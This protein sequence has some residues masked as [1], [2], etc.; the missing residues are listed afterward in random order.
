MVDGKFRLGVRVDP[1][2]IPLGDFVRATRQRYPKLELEI[3][4]FNSLNILSGIQSGELDAGFALVDR[5]PSGLAALDLERVGYLIVAPA[6]WRVDVEGADLDALRKLP[7]IGAPRGGSHDQMLLSLFGEGS[8]S[9]NRVVDAAQEVMHAILVEAGVGLALMQED[10][11]LL[12]EKR[13]KAVVWKGARATS[14]LRFMHSERR[15]TDPAVRAMRDL[16][17]E[18]WD[19]ARET[20]TTW[21][22]RSE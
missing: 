5:L 18:F 15:S 10:R 4:Q 6:D 20:G 7:W 12:A 19:A 13:G 9:L 3:L 22:H 11:A 8:L 17:A 21:S 14:M 16:A 1:G 2:L